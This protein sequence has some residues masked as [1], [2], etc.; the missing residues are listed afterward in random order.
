MEFLYQSR[1]IKFKSV[2][3]TLYPFEKCC[4]SV[5]ISNCKMLKSVYAI[6]SDESGFYLKLPMLHIGNNEYKCEFSLFECGLYFYHF[7]IELNDKTYVSF[8]RNEYNNPCVCGKEWRISVVPNDTN[9]HLPLGGIMYQIFPDRFNIGRKLSANDLSNKLKPYYIHKNTAE[10]PDYIFKDEYC[11]DFFGGNL[12]GIT[13]KLKYIKS[14][15]VNYIY[16]NPIFKAQSNHRYDTADYMTI[17]PM[18]GSEEDF[19]NLCDKAHELNI[20]IILDA[21]FSH[22]GSNSIYFDKKKIFGG[23]AYS[24]G[25]SS[26]YYEWYDFI[27]YPEKYE[28]WWGINT[29]PRVNKDINSYI[30]YIIT[31][32]NS[33]INHWMELGADGFRLDV[34]D[35]LPDSFILLIQNRVKENSDTSLLIG[36]VWENAAEKISYGI[37][38]KYF[39]DNELDGVMNYPFR[40]A[41]T[42]LL[43]NELNC[44]DFV[45]L[46][47]DIVESYPHKKLCNSMMF[48]SSHDTRRILSELYFGNKSYTKKEQSEMS[49]PKCH[50]QE[51]IK[52]LKCA[53]IISISLP[54]IFSIFYGDEAGLEG[55][56]DPFNRRFF[57]YGI[58]NKELTEFYRAV[59]KIKSETEVLNIGKTTVIHKDE[60][61]FIKR[62]SEKETTE[63]VI[64]LSSKP[65]IFNDSNTLIVC[66]YNQ[67]A[68]DKYGFF[69]K[70]TLNNTKK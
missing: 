45:E 9:C 59:C 69:I 49:I 52:K 38:R 4:F 5:Y 43:N 37:R 15:S 25:I 70:K 47:M 29:L 65:Y 17:D 39:T 35:E 51:V 13:E 32:N 68:I 36:E 48:L 58:E 3:G 41:V 55:M 31:A 67:K 44:D 10:C 28:S 50:L 26:K 63:T 56:D 14:F 60:I 34:A 62:F 23:G 20:K 61:L 21:V 12:S 64:N 22:T 46:I 7:D 53:L 19:I 2:F 1:D 54:G 18:L 24:S 16:L 33:V 11:C 6:I 57:P 27:E 8:F 40:N 66:K 30:D 42:K